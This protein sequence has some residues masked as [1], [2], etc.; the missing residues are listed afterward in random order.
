MCEVNGSVISYKS[1]EHLTGV[2]VVVSEK[3]N[4]VAVARL[5]KLEIYSLRPYE[6][7]Q[8]IAFSNG[9]GFCMDPEETVL[10]CYDTGNRILV[11]DTVTWEYEMKYID[12][13]SSL[14]DDEFEIGKM[15]Y[16][17][18]GLILIASLT[19]YEIYIH[20][21]NNGCSEKVYELSDD[22]D[23]TSDKVYELSA[24][25][26]E[27]IDLKYDERK[28]S[29]TFVEKEYPRTCLE[30]KWFE[31]KKIGELK[32]KTAN[33][34]MDINLL[35]LTEKVLFCDPEKGD[36]ILYSIKRRLFS[37]WRTVLTYCNQSKNIECHK[38]LDV[39]FKYKRFVN[40]S[41]LTSS[42]LGNDGGILIPFHYGI[43]ICWIKNDKIIHEESFNVGSWLHDYEVYDDGR[44]IIATGEEGDVIAA[45]KLN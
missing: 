39:N 12:I 44:S 25:C 22:C 41:R 32:S 28:N 9:A 29:L 23:E 27:I 38:E 42:A 10:M 33:V 15:F 30:N 31:C 24:D 8:D 14:E 19:Y 20:D 7:I 2:A 11:I 5:S 4:F 36:C 34:S 1:Y 35:K 3:R 26:E 17:S 18:H 40:Y 21:I 45:I 13:E 43:C 16:L 6:K 37:R